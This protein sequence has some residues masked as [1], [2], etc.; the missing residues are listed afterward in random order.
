MAN[1][2]FGKYP[3]ENITLLSSLSPNVG[4]CGLG[5]IRSSPP[6]QSRGGLGYGL[7]L[8]K[9]LTL[10][11]STVF[12]APPQDSIKA[13]DILKNSHLTPFKWYSLLY[14]CV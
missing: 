6:S 13:N 7:L 11:L 14:L 3:K 12:F 8:K 2:L 10:T 4:G 9:T 5:R 1:F